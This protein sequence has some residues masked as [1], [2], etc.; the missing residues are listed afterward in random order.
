M[1]APQPREELENVGTVEFLMDKD[2]NFYFI[3]VNS[4]LQVEH[5]VTE[6]RAGLD[7]VK[8]QLEIA[9]G[10]GI[11]YTQDDIELNGAAIQCR[12]NAEDPE[13]GFAPSTGRIENL[14]FP[15]GSGVRIDT[16]IYPGYVVPEY[17]DSLLAKLIVR[18]SNL[19]E[20]AK[21]MALALDEL[22]IQGVRTTLP[23]Q[24]FIL[25]RREFTNWDLDILFMQKNHIIESFVEE[26]SRRRAKLAAQG[27][28]IAAVVLESGISR[29][30]SGA[31]TQQQPSQPMRQEARYYDAL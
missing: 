22:D 1:L 7:L 25:K 6:M 9:A 26:T 3:E 2:Q 11:D 20:A 14:F 21:R 12:I 15:G 8:E 18:G 24:R 29:G 17:Y 28:A 19:D 16:A 13:A 10:E 30:F 4:R 31:Q 5:T 27:A 23:L